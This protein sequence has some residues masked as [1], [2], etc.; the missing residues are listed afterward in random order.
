MLHLI[1]ITPANLPTLN[2]AQDTGMGFSVA[3]ESAWSRTVLP[4]FLE[5]GDGS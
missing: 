5:Q 3:V 4:D 1:K 2:S